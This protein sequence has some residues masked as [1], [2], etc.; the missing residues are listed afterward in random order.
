[1]RAPRA[2]SVRGPVADAIRGAIRHRRN[3]YATLMMLPRPCET[4]EQIEII[5]GAVV[6]TPKN[7]GRR[8]LAAGP[9]MGPTVR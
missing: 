6:A 1:M 5:T 8:K 7:T 3:D 4:C 9:V 2:G